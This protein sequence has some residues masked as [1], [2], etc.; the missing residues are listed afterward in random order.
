MRETD[1]LTAAA[2]SA[3]RP[4]LKSEA[5]KGSDAAP[6]QVYPFSLRAGSATAP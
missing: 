4:W 3:K 6:V 2:K 5:K 1:P